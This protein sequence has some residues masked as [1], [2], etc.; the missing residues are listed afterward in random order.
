ME[1]VSRLPALT[2]IDKYYT[3]FID[4]SVQQAFL[5]ISPLLSP[6]LLFSFSPFNQILTLNFFRATTSSTASMAHITQTSVRMYCAST[7][8]I[9]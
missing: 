4:Y 6:F 8:C 3:T 9:I 7:P 1:G 5:L 2:Y